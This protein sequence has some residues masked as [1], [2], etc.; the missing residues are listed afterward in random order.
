MTARKENRLE[1]VKID[2]INDYFIEVDELN[3]TLKQTYKGEDKKGNPKEG[4]ERVIGY[5][6]DVQACVERLIRLVALDET[7]KAVISMKEYAESAEKAFQ[8]VKRWRNEKETA[9]T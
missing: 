6:P 1:K 4:C 9:S 2:L 8:K 5:F 3:H 7:D